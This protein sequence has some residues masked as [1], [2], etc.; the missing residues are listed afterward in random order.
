MAMPESERIDR[1]RA[2][3]IAY[4]VCR[5]ALTPSDPARR[6]VMRP[7]LEAWVGMIELAR[8]ADVPVIYTTPVSRADGAD[9]ILLPTDL[10]ADTGVPPLTNAIEGTAEAGFPDKIAPRPEDYV[11][12]K[13]RPSAFY[14]TGVAELLRML[15]RDTIIIGG[16][17]TNRGVET[18]V[19]EAFNL[20]LASVVVRECC[21]SSDT[22]AHAYSL[23][24]AMKMYARIRTVD[25]VAAM[26]RE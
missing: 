24:K 3:L 5:R 13:R 1:G 17:A 21:W 4:D 25:Q 23:D 18:S 11:F 14:G 16:G 7:V 26:L 22:T 10:S 19:R 20:D 6:A 15:R 2:A 12:L 9:V 8:T